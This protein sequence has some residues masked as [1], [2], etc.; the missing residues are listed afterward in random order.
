MLLLKNVAPSSSNYTII[1]PLNLRK[2]YFERTPI[3]EK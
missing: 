2:F 1:F 3:E